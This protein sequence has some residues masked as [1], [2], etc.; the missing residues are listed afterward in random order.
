MF[1]IGV[2]RTAFGMEKSHRN[3][4]CFDPISISLNRCQNSL[5][6]TFLAFCLSLLPIGLS[7][8]A[9]SG[10]YCRTF[11][12]SGGAAGSGLACRQ[13]N[14]WQIRT[15]TQPVPGPGRD[16]EYRTASSSLPPAILS[17]VQ[18]Q[19]VGDPLDRAAEIA[20]RE[21]GWRSAGKSPA[22]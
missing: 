3:E 22:H 13:T 15:L 10:E 9:K 17:A 19:I 12:I 2:F 20:A 5:S 18:D 4:Q 11:S 16:S 14:Q 21:Q 6:L 8:L 7:F 1:L